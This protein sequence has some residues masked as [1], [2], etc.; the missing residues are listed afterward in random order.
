MHKHAVDV[1]GAPLLP[2]DILRYTLV[3]TNPHS[4]AVAGVV[5]S[6]ALPLHTAYVAGSATPPADADVDPLV[7][8]EQSFAAGD[9]R[10]TSISTRVW[11]RRPSVKPIANPAWLPQPGNP[12]TCTAGHAPR[13]GS[14][15]MVLPL[16]FQKAAF[17]VNAGH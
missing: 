16:S 15:G 13:P 17:G 2:G 6:D 4:L 10:T 12:Q 14:W 9:A 8:S 11:K 7:W 1:N 5:I 3:V